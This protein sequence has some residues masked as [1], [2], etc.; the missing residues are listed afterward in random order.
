MEFA[1]Q[2]KLELSFH[3]VGFAFTAIDSVGFGIGILIIVA[4]IIIIISNADNS[5]N[6][7]C[8]ISHACFIKSTNTFV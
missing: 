4:I 2:N 6:G 7:H 1:D 3:K 8:I 5:N